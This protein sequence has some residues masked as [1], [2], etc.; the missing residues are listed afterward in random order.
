[1]SR[2]CAPPYTGLTLSFKAEKKLFEVELLKHITLDDI[3]ILSCILREIYTMDF[4]LL[5]LYK[6][7]CRLHV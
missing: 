4:Y 6:F 5:W 2:K 3:Q 7:Q 1:M